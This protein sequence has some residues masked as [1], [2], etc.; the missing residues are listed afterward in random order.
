MSL[1]IA[2]TAHI[3]IALSLLL[4]A[5]HGMG[6]LFVRLRQPRVIGEI[7]G[8]LLLGP[9]VLGHFFP[10]I[11][12]TAFPDYD[13][14]TFSV[15]GAVYQLGLLL[16]MYCSGLEVRSSFQQKERRTA[17][18]ITASGTILPF[19]LGI[20][21]LSLGVQGSGGFL[22]VSRFYGP[23]DHSTAFMLVFAV[24]I[25]VTSIPVI[26][27]IMFDLDLL[28]TPFA[29]IVL[30][31]AVIE[32]ILLYIVL[33]VALG[34]VG[35]GSEETFGLQ[36]LLGLDSSSG[37]GKLFHIVAPLAFIFLSLTAGPGL[38]QRLRSSRIN[39]LARSSPIA[40]LLVFMLMM[41]GLCV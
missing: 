29:R 11:Q 20:G 41:T 23:A 33:A 30:G 6:F 17:L 19:C 18:L 10:D 39:L 5:A 8:G 9:S 35:S 14:A 13:G 7:L 31:A 4:V 32:D 15:L 16:L 28:E 27:R 12:R 25:A 38:Y 22:D 2:Q 40:F 36:N 34:M 21:I 37:L 26:S 24:A 3:L 1:T